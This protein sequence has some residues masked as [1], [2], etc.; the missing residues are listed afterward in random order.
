MA[1][2]KVQSDYHSPVQ[3]FVNMFKYTS[4]KFMRT[5]LEEVMQDNDGKYLA[6]IIDPTPDEVKVLDRAV[7][8]IKYLEKVK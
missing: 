4:M 3:T 2:F 7:S 8:T 5:R 1:Q 6:V